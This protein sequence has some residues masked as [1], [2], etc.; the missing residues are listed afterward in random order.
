[1]DIYDKDGRRIDFKE[2]G[3]LSD[4]D[5]YRRIGLTEI[6]PYTVSTVW[7]GLD[8]SYMGGGPPIIFETM[9]F[10]TSAWEAD[11]SDPDH[12]LL[13]EIDARRYCTLQEA[14]DGHVEQCLIVR[15]TVNEEIPTEPEKHTNEGGGT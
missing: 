3:R 13:M 6:G 7:L 10:T 12:E 8:H 15:A 2:W 11:R 9:V 4:D 5:D 1:M 14:M